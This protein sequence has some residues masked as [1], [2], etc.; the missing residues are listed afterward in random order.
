[1]A[2]LKKMKK[3]FLYN[4]KKQGIL[5]VKDQNEEP[6]NLKSGKKSRV[7]WDARDAMRYSNF[8]STVG[9]LMAETFYKPARLHFPPDQVI[10]VPVGALPLAQATADQWDY[11]NGSDQ[12]DLVLLR[13]TPK[14]HGNASAENWLVGSSLASAHTCVIEDTV[15]TAGSLLKV[16]DTLQNK[17]G[18]N[19]TTAMSLIDRSFGTAEKALAEQNV[20]F[21]SV[22]TMEDLLPPD[23]LEEERANYFA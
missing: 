22:F 1:M 6:F 15:T 11:V 13:D 8:R 2:D 12:P 17:A 9:R 18:V 3:D 5:I 4:A 21:R 10:G 23:L 16:I 7:Y 19:V 14:T 20:K